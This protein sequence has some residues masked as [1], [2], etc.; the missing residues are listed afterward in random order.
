MTEEPS[1]IRDV[2]PYESIEQARAQLD[3]VLHGIPGMDAPGAAGEVVVTEALLL[4]GV[5]ISGWEDVQRREIMRAVS[6][7]D[8]QV[9][10]GWVLRARL[11][12]RRP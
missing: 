2:G 9:I 3:A 8:A 12:D 11:A 7:E 1:A 6:P 4:A 10:A 5:Q